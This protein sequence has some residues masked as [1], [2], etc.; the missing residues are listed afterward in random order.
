MK[1][2]NLVIILSLAFCFVSVSHASTYQTISPLTKDGSIVK[3]IALAKEVQNS[4]YKK[5]TH[6]L[7]EQLIQDEKK[8]MN[9][10]REEQRALEVLT[11]KPSKIMRINSLSTFF[12]NLFGG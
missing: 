8:L 10:Y 12:Q 7:L 1:N 6:S 3:S 11:N 9:N 4:Q 5:S 2:T